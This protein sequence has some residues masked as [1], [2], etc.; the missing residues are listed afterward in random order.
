MDSDNYLLFFPEVVTS[1]AATRKHPKPSNG[2]VKAQI[3]AD[4]RSLISIKAPYSQ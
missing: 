1:D 2:H 4:D 3:Q